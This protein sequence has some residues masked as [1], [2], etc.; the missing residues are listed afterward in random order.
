MEDK[1][2][3]HN[4]VCDINPNKLCDSCGACIASGE[5]YKIVYAEFNLPSDEFIMMDD[6]FDDDDDEIPPIDVDPTLLAQWD[7]KL[8]DLEA[9][10]QNKPAFKHLK[11]QR[12]K[13]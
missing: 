11:G 7:A 12:K 5:D 3:N 13:V 8:D 9:N 10:E 6:D 2:L 1:Y 4:D